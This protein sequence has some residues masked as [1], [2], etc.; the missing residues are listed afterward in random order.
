M[1]CP[2]TKRG[3]HQGDLQVLLLW[4]QGEGQAA[5][6][7]A[8]RGPQTP[9]PDSQPFPLTHT[10]VFCPPFWMGPFA[11]STSEPNF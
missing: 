5:G 1:A 2:P 6:F 9:T 8:P 7:Q 3:Q 10:D 4:E 11:T